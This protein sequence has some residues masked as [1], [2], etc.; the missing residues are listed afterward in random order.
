MLLGALCVILGYQ[1][2]WLWAS[3][4]VYGSTSGLLPPNAFPTGAYKYLN[5]ERGLIAGAALF[6][7]GLGLNLW[8]VFEWFDKDLGA[9]E[10]RSTLRYVLWGFTTLVLGVQTIYGSFFLSMLCLKKDRDAEA[11]PAPAVA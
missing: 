6:L 2:L 8:L 7:I 10:I 9:L 4:R 3:A 5:L 11:G 1:T